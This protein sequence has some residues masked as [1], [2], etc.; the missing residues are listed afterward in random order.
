MFAASLPLHYGSFAGMF[1]GGLFFLMR[2]ID[3]RHFFLILQ[4][5]DYCRKA[6]KKLTK[7]IIVSFEKSTSTPGPLYNTVHYNRIF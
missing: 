7:D 5:H 3:S 2:D 4:G 1:A 6:K